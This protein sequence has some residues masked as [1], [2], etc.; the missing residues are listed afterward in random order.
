M[1][2]ILNR[3]T[4]NNTIEP[5]GSFFYWSDN[6]PQKSKKPCAYPGCLKLIT[7]G[8]F[9]IK[10]Q[11]QRQKQRRE[12]DRYYDKH[13]RNKKSKGF[14]KSR[15]WQAVR[16]RALIRDHYLCQDCLK[17]HRVTKA[18]T[19]HHLIEISEDYSKRLVLN[20]LISLCNACH[21]SRHGKK[22]I[23]DSL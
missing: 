17:Q 8:R 12:T 16:R 2:N 23:K 15:A 5:L 3:S 18:D 14:Y 6:V 7:D 22:L 1:K 21:N 13:L 11:N 4:V 9:C 20:N 10:H 19:V